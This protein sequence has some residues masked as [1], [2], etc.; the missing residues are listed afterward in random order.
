[1]LVS[2]YV[3]TA[4]G[5]PV[6]LHYCGGELEEISY[7]TKGSDCCGEEIPSGNNDCCQDEGLL[8]INSPDFTLKNSAEADFVKTFSQLFFIQL[9]YFF[10]LPAEQNLLSAFH[11]SFPPPRVQNGILISVT[12]LRI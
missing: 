6:Y 5:V 11:H 7:L 8:L 4:A 3:F 1:M 12:V 9:P 2:A 10:N